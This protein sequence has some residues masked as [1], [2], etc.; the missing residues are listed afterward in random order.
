MFFPF[1]TKVLLERFYGRIHSQ[2]LILGF[3]RGESVKSSDDHIRE[4]DLGSSD[5]QSDLG[6]GQIDFTEVEQ[7]LPFTHVAQQSSCSYLYLLSFLNKSENK[8][9]M[10]RPQLAR[11]SLDINL[12][13]ISYLQE[14]IIGLLSVMD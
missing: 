10:K 2:W 7:Q 13:I 5:K 12:Y 14:I 6:R 3:Y 9:K 1:K 11:R 8:K 4:R